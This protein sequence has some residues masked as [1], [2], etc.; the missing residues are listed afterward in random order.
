M[1]NRN[2]GENE[3]LVIFMCLAVESESSSSVAKR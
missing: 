2:V 1:V 3:K